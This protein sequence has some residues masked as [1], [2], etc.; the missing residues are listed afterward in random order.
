MKGRPIPR[1]RGRQKKFA[2]QMILYVS[3]SVAIVALNSFISLSIYGRKVENLFSNITQNQ[4]LAVIYEEAGKVKNALESY[5]E[6]GD[7]AY[8]T[9]FDGMKA[10]LGEKVEE[11][12]MVLG[13][14]ENP[15]LTV[16]RGNLTGLFRTFIAAAQETFEAKRTGD[17]SAY[18]ADYE[19]LLD[20]YK[21]IDLYIKEIM[22]AQLLEKAEQYELYKAQMDKIYW[23]SIFMMLIITLLVLI[24]IMT[25]SMEMTRPVLRLKE[26]AKR[27][28]ERDFDFLI[29]EESSSEEMQTL[30]RAFAKMKDGIR[31]YLAMREKQQELEEQLN[32]QRIANLEMK[33][34]LKEAELQ[35]L[36]AQIDPHFLFNTINIGAQMATMHDDDETADYFYRVADL[37]R[38]TS[39]G[40]DQDATLREEVNHGLNYIGLMKVRF[41]DKYQIR[42]ENRVE[43]SDL[44]LP[45]PKM[46]LQPVIENAYVHGLRKREGGGRLEMILEREE[47]RIL[48]RI[49]DNGP[50]IHEERARQILA[51]EYREEEEKR[52]NG[53]GLG[54]VIGRLRLWCGQ[55]EVM[56]ISCRDG[57]TEFVLMLPVNAQER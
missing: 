21:G 14:D 29:P 56:G 30:Y 26:Y 40:F 22:S 43:E 33:N 39:K 35:T 12:S 6:T 10:S 4:Q 18:V 24:L 48:V 9:E 19:R 25:Y 49:R 45:V 16:Q 11:E 7:E 55:E 53:I 2:T 37:F 28:E 32:K 51:G 3:I 41:G 54:N 13:M 47:E 46:I 23:I 8:I 57:V 20:V 31:D 52:G 50:G 27:V 5:L 17:V 36:Q 34:S 42:Y 15:D 38:Y 1:I 44:E